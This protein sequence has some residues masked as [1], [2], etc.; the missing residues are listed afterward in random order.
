VL[1]PREY[2]G[3]AESLRR[4]HE[5][6][7]HA[8]IRR[9]FYRRFRRR[10]FVIPA[11]CVVVPAVAV[12]IVLFAVG[13]DGAGEDCSDHCPRGAICDPGY[14]IGYYVRRPDGSS[15]GCDFDVVPPGEVLGRNPA[16]DRHRRYS[17][18]GELRNDGM[19]AGGGGIGILPLRAE[20]EI[21]AP[22]FEPF[23]FVVRDHCLRPYCGTCLDA[24]IHAT[25]MPTADVPATIERMRRW[26][27]LVMTVAGK[28]LHALP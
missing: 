19:C 12:A 14:V 15:I 6:E 18:I 24:E 2:N 17:L 25:L 8:E 23:R 5:F 20:F 1:T 7:L 22:G 3:L 13:R 21:R 4:R 28:A 9:E 27:D 16:L 26:R 11:V 10:R